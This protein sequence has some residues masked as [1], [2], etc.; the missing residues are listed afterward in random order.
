[1]FGTPQ[2]SSITGSD[3]LRGPAGSVIGLVVPLLERTSVRHR[4]RI[5]LKAPT[6]RPST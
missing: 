4:A 6:A 3:L 1:M 5:E 2:L